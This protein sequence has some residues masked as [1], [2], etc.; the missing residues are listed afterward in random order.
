MDIYNMINKYEK[1]RNKFFTVN[2]I[3]VQ[4]KKLLIKE[5]NLEYARKWLTQKEERLSFQNG[6]E[7]VSQIR[8][9]KTLYKN[10]MML[11]NVLYWFNNYDL[12]KITKSD[13]KHIFMNLEK[14][15][16]KSRSGKTLTSGGKS[17]YYTKM[18]KGNNTFFAY[19][20]KNNLAKEVI[21]RK[22]TEN[23]EVRF[24][25]YETFKT[26]ESNAI[27]KDHK[28]CFWLLYDTGSEI[29]ALCQLTKSDFIKEIDN[30]KNTYYKIKISK[31]IS[32]KSRTKRYIDLIYPETNQLIET[33]LKNLKEDELIFKFQPPAIYRA[34]KLIIKK[35]NLRTK[36]D[37]SKE[38]TTKDFRS[39]CATRLMSAYNYQP[40]EVKIR[41]GHRLSSN[42]IDRYISFLNLD[43]KKKRKEIQ[44][45][46][47]QELQENFNK[48]KAISINQQK[49]INHLKENWKKLSEFYQEEEV[50]KQFLTEEL[51]KIDY[52][53]LTKPLQKLMN[54]KSKVLTPDTII[55]KFPLF[56]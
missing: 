36:G 40:H 25:D 4:H 5:K 47:Y 52:G 44:N 1:V 43:Q 31:D 15:N 30:N 41:I 38:I 50:F 56:E 34:L 19:L 22:Y 10:I 33:H 27:T 8:N 46:N 29:S 20:K 35:H 18:F 12:K 45:M 23:E 32:K 26:I 48:L 21:I 24:F 55:P 7:K 16:L 49:E 11:K 14:N 17:E 2:T 51:E 13:I 54:T 53:H 3:K 42:T 39:S 9:A 28:L 6:T 37:T